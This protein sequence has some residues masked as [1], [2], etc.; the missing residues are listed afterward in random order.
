IHGGTRPW[1]VARHAGCAV[2]WFIAADQVDASLAVILSGCRVVYLSR[3]KVKRDGHGASNPRL[4][5]SRPRDS[6]MSN[7]FTLDNMAQQDSH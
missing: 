2:A 3:V 5:A 4:N 7:N 6:G 1:F